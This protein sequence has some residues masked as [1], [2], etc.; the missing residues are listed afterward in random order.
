MSVLF[1]CRENKG[2]SQIAKAYFNQ[3]NTAFAESAGTQVETNDDFDKT[4]KLADFAVA[5][6]V[7][8]AMKED[9]VDISSYTRRQVTPEMAAQFSRIVIMAEAETVPEWLVENERAE[10]WSVEDL[11][12]QPLDRTRQI[13]DEIKTKVKNLNGEQDISF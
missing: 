13:R 7:I 11:K 2:R 10:V 12:D 8:L 1:V 5:E 9:G 4:K 3:F 6:T